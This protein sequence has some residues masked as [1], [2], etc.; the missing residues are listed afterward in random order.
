VAPEGSPVLLVAVTTV[1]RW[2]IGPRSPPAPRRP[3]AAPLPRHWQAASERI[4]QTAKRR[5]PR[6]QPV[7]PPL[8]CADSARVCQRS[9]RLADVSRHEDGMILVQEYE[10]EPSLE[11]RGQRV[12][13]GINWWSGLVTAP[14]YWAW[15]TGINGTLMAHAG[16]WR[17]AG[18]AGWGVGI[19]S[20]RRAC[21]V[22]GLG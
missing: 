9:S 22:A 12:V 5:Q 1:V 7:T 2:G 21:L 3:R 19:P 10:C 11:G 13:R 16:C 4:L 14:H 15:L 8:T 20:R 17:A 6:R 18:R